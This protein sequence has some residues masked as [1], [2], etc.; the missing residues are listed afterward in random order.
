MTH[1]TGTQQ[2]FF[3][4]LKLNNKT[5]RKRRATRHPLNVRKVTTAV[6]LSADEPRHS[7]FSYFQ[8][9]TTKKSKKCPIE[10]KNDHPELKD[11]SLQCL[12]NLVEIVRVSITS[13]Y[14][15]AV[16]HLKEKSDRGSFTRTSRSFCTN[17]HPLFKS[18]GRSKESTAWDDVLYDSAGKERPQSACCWRTS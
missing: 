12:G 18:R 13:C 11:K 15:E 9:A 3:P 1:L 14:R 4:S 10:G 5:T 8:K 7:F 17:I 16:F 2:Y 6:N